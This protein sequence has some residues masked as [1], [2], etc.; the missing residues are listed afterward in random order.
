[1]YRHFCRLILSIKIVHNINNI[2]IVCWPLQWDCGVI[3]SPSHKLEFKDKQSLQLFHFLPSTFR[4]WTK[5][6]IKAKYSGIPDMTESILQIFNE[7]RSQGALLWRSNKLRL[8][9]Q[10]PS[11]FPDI[12]SQKLMTAL[13]LPENLELWEIFS[14]LI[15]NEFLESS[16]LIFSQMRSTARAPQKNLSPLHGEKL[17]IPRNKAIDDLLFL[18]VPGLWTTYLWYFSSSFSFSLSCSF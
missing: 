16:S 8:A 5:F 6:H 2:I 7:M 12:Q 10:R 14:P 13:W 17:S 3:V 1:M 18:H 9:L 15:S 11:R 4:N